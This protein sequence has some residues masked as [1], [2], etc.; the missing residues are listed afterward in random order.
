MGGGDEQESR[1]EQRGGGGGE[2]CHAAGHTDT[3]A[4]TQTHAPS[5]QVASQFIL[6]HGAGREG[7]L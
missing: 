5:T 1:P 3:R 4:D 7:G 6:G 2:A